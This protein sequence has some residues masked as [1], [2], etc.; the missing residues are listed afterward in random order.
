MPNIR[1]RNRVVV[2]GFRRRKTRLLFR[3]EE[4]CEGNNT[5][6]LSVPDASAREGVGQNPLSLYS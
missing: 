6:P 1:T 3:E 5:F 2:L 4:K